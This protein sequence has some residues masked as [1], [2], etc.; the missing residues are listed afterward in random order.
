VKVAGV[1]GAVCN[2]VITEHAFTTSVTWPVAPAVTLTVTDAPQPS[3]VLVGLIVRPTVVG[4]RVSDIDIVASSK[5]KPSNG[6]Q[7]VVLLELPEFGI[8]RAG[9]LVNM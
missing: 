1:N 3:Q 4:L 9:M 5:P 8:T 6:L 2:S 7:P